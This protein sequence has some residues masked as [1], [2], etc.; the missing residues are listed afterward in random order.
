MTSESSRG[1]TRRSLLK[2]GACTLAACTTGGLWT[3]TVAADDA[4][5]RLTSARLP[6]SIA[7]VRLPDSRLARASAE[8]AHS[9]SPE[10]LYNHCI[11]TYV[12]AALTFRQQRVRFDEEQLFVASALHDLGLIDAYMTPVERFEI[13]GADAAVSFL[14]QQGAG[15]AFREVVWDAIALHTF[16]SYAA[17]KAP[18][19]AGV[20]LGAGMDAFG[21]GLSELAP[22]D[23]AAVLTALPRLDAK[24]SVIEST[25]RFCE[26]KPQGVALTGLAEVGRKY[27]PD[28]AAPTFEDLILAAPFDE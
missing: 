25:I 14:Q 5:S 13:D 26:K 2:T 7:G 16:G 23:V 22:E 20:S 21:L 10:T 15:R 4:A 12:F 28:F 11:R 17:R 19:I 18:E 27:L 8:L 1:L 24:R 3:H 9:V 6:K